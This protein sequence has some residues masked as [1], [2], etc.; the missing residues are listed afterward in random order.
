MLKK[1]KNTLENNKQ[2]IIFQN[3]RGYA[4]Y[5]ECSNCAYVYQ[6]INCDVS[7]TYH[8]VSNEL[9]CHHCGYRVEN[10]TT[11]PTC[12][13]N[14]SIKKGLGTQQVVEELE[15]YFPSFKIE[16]MDH[17]STRTKN[18]FSNIIADFENN[19]F[20]ILVGTQMLTKGLD[21]KN[22]SWCC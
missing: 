20:Q 8:Q 16:R 5:L 14:T 9:K 10:K 22:V 21:F 11:C 4:P 13:S 19:K 2:V 7:L 3:R 17:D 15:Q 12:Y 6:C 18:A 1:I